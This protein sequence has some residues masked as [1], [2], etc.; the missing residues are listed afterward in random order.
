MGTA[1]CAIGKR[2][3]PRVA[4]SN[5]QRDTYGAQTAHACIGGQKS[6]PIVIA[7]SDPRMHWFARYE[8]R[9]EL[10]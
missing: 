1:D 9:P 4:E 5:R 3:A 7:V 8:L 10:S 2:R 6:L